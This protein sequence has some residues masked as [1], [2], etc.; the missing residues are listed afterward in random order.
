MSQWPFRTISCCVTCALEKT[1]TCWVINIQVAQA[2]RRGRTVFPVCVC[3]LPT[4]PP[5]PSPSVPLLFYFYFDLCDI[6]FFVCSSS[7]CL[8]FSYPVFLHF[9]FLMQFFPLPV[10][11]YS[12]CLIFWLFQFFS[13][14][15]FICSSLFVSCT[16]HSGSPG[17]V[18]YLLEKDFLPFSLDF[19]HLIILFST[20]HLPW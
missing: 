20:S 16:I 6:Q 3:P 2:L 19:S 4:P 13:L 14:G 9:Y 17:F 18:S 1:N 12:R 8:F 5:P 10:C 15:I 7:I 11:I